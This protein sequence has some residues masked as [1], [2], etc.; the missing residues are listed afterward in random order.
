MSENKFSPTIVIT[1]TGRLERYFAQ[2][3]PSFN[4]S[5]D[6]QTVRVVN[7]GVES[8]EMS[9][10]SIRL[11]GDVVFG[12]NTVDD[13]CFE[14]AKLQ[15]KA[16]IVQDSGSKRLQMVKILDFA[17]RRKK[18]NDLFT[19]PPLVVVSN[20]TASP[21][22]IAAAGDFPPSESYV[23]KPVHASDGE[24]QM[25]VSLKESCNDAAS[26][27]QMLW[28]IMH[29]IKTFLCRTTPKD[30]SPSGSKANLSVHPLTEY[31]SQKYLV[32]E[33]ATGFR[34][35]MSER[36][37]VILQHAVKNIA[38]EYRAFLQGGKVVRIMKRPRTEC[39]YPQLQKGP[40]EEVQLED[41]AAIRDI[42]TA[43]PDLVPDMSS[44][45]IFTTHDGKWGVFE[46]GLGYSPAAAHISFIRQYFQDF[47]T[48][49]LVEKLSTQ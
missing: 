34:P 2:L 16:V 10:Q 28:D 12:E 32:N 23:I 11:V 42:Y 41:S 14:W 1:C 38:A 36:G 48:T 24:S 19:F 39:G 43:L 44:A 17:A 18:V 46:F 31:L 45:D 47:V 20:R 49:S 3:P 6:N 15:N 26:K 7:A 4:V 8:G 40:D 21:G 27:T 5:I 33:C 13:M 35:S 9:A 25:M 30:E 22:K 29:G 37:S